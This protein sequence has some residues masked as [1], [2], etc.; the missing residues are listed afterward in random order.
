MAAGGFASGGTA[1]AGGGGVCGPLMMRGL[2]IV[3]VVDREREL[4]EMREFVSSSSSWRRFGRGFE[5]VP[6]S[7]AFRAC[8]YA[9]CGPPGTCRVSAQLATA[10]TT[11]TL[12]HRN[13]MP[14]P[15]NIV[16]PAPANRPAA[17]QIMVKELLRAAPIWSRRRQM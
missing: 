10:R 13:G 1:L 16:L 4:S 9:R 11:K 15:L 6:S 14:S 8:A 3:S 7:G 5:R 2:R 12:D 17:S